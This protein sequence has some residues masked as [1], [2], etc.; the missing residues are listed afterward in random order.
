MKYRSFIMRISDQ[1]FSDLKTQSEKE[2]RS[3]AGIVKEQIREYLTSKNKE[4]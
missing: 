2:N 4:Q 1:L 3:M